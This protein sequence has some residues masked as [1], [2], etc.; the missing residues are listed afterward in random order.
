MATDVSKHCMSYNV[1]QQANK[2]GRQKP[3]MVGRPIL[4]M[5]LAVDIVG[6]I[7]KCKRLVEDRLETMR[8]VA[9]LKMTE[10]QKAR[11]AVYDKNS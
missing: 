5:P 9:A 1:C 10:S 3:P 6:P 2:R 4:T 11:K 8:E 7:P